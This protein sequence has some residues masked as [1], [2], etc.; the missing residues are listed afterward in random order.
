[1]LAAVVIEEH[2]RRTVHLADDDA[3]GA[4]DDEGAVGRHE[5]HVAHVDVLLLDVLD[6]LGAG[7]LV[8]IEHD[9]AQ[10]HLQRRREGH[11]ALLALVDVVLRRLELVAHEL[12]R[13]AAREVGDREHRPEYG[14]QTLVQP[15]AGRLLDHQEVIVG[16]LLHLDEVR[17][18]GDFAD[19][20]EL[21]SDALAAVVGLSH[22]GSSSF[23]REG[24]CVA[25]C[26]MPQRPAASIDVA[27]RAFAT[28]GQWARSGRGKP[29]S[30]LPAAAR[31]CVLI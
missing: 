17:H 4:V 19:R 8:H 21:L 6:R 13:R 2:A 3:L 10:L 16:T 9:Q 12:Q 29:A 18:L 14:L 20:P 31:A 15:A 7:L 28:R 11:V 25:T 26:G 5:R 27:S 23:A 22:L 1:M 24:C 30:R